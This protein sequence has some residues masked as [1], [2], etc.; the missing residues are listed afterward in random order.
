MGQLKSFSPLFTAGIF[1]I[2]FL[3]LLL[4]GFNYMLT[5]LEAR[6]DHIETRM[7][8]IESKLDQLISQKIAR[9]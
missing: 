2:S 3:V 1:L 7:D 5:P 9:K 8:R 4:A 6:M